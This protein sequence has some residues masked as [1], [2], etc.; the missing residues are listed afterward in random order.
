MASKRNSVKK[1]KTTT[2]AVSSRKKN[3]LKVAPPPPPPPP[4]VEAQRLM[5]STVSLQK[6]IDFTSQ[7]TKTCKD[8]SIVLTG[9]GT[10]TLD[11]TCGGCSRVYK[12]RLDNEA[13]HQFPIADAIAAA[14]ICA[15]IGHRAVKTVFNALELPMIAFETY[16]EGEER[17]GKRLKEVVAEEVKLNGEEERRL[18]I[19]AGDIIKIGDEEF[20][21][22]SV[23][24]DAGWSKRS[25]GHS[26][27]ANS[28]TATIIGTRTKKTLFTDYRTKTCVIC[29]KYKNSQSSSNSQTALA[30]S[31][32]EEESPGTSDGQD[33]SSALP[34][35]NCYKN[36]SG[37]SQSMEADILVEG[38]KCS[39]QQHGLIYKY[40]V[41]DADSSVYARIQKEVI[42]PG[43]TPIE[44][45]DCVNHAVRGLNS[46]LYHLIDNTAYSKR[47]RNEVSK[48]MAR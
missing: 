7:H 27:S 35:H 25:Y 45:H 11:L 33:E 34:E 24:V 44:K 19:E 12:Y 17:V 13:S 5:L 9:I 10:K 26:Y 14:A 38:F 21:F 46:K 48:N 31:D 22:I 2:R 3:S 20:P 43:R 32:E 15:G 47:D 41:G 37:S 40:L 36:F 18:A 8:C 4:E 6:I 16:Q 1:K 29:D 42:Y 30:D 23:T 28:G 39:L